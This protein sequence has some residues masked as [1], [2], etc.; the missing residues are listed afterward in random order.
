[1]VRVERVELPEFQM[2]V[3]SFGRGKK[4]LVILPGLSVKR[5]TDQAGAVKRAYKNFSEEYTVYLFDRREEVPEGY[6]ISDMAEDTVR[7]MNKLRLSDINLFGASQGGMIAMCIAMNH[8]AL[9][10]RLVLGSTAYRLTDEL[11]ES[12]HQWIGAAGQGISGKLNQ[13]FI[14]RV[15]GQKTMEKYGKMLLSVSPEYSKEELERFDRLASAMLDMDLENGLSKITCPTMVLGSRGDRVVGPEA[16][17]ALAR[18]LS[19]AC[20]L[21]GPEYGHAV[22]DEAPDYTDRIKRFLENN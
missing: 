2:R 18:K 17:E 7:V 22:Y 14:R 6:R 11:K 12:L 5:T 1:M 13:A 3:A 19:C 10:R 9:V 21:Y 8:P 20:E 15:Y 16:A 4:T